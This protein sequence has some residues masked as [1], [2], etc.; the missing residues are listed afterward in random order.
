MLWNNSLGDLTIDLSGQGTNPDNTANV[1]FID[2]G[3]VDVEEAVVVVAAE[4]TEVVGE[5]EEVAALQKLRQS[6]LP[7]RHHDAATTK[8]KL[9]NKNTTHRVQSCITFPIPKTT[10]STLAGVLWKKTQFHC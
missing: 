6:P 8:K 9:T 10:C 2:T 5:A 3:K 4:E 7:L 1:T